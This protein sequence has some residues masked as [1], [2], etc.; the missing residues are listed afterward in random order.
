VT[1]AERGGVARQRLA[2]VGDRLAMATGAGGEFRARVPGDRVGRVQAQR[3]V[4]VGERLLDEA[5]ARLAGAAVKVGAGG[6]VAGGDGLRVALKRPRYVLS[7]R[8]RARAAAGI[9]RLL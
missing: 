1:R 2:E 4:D 9:R 8:K 5:E 3:R 7:A 6:R